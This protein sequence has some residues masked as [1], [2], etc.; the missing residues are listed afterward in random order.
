M[1][2]PSQQ[3]PLRAGGLSSLVLQAHGQV[4]AH[5]ALT[6]SQIACLPVCRARV[7]LPTTPKFVTY[8]ADMESWCRGICSARS[9]SLIS[10]TLAT[11]IPEMQTSAM[12]RAVQTNTDASMQKLCMLA[13]ASCATRPSSMSLQPSAPRLRAGTHMPHGGFLAG[14]SQ[15]VKFNSHCTGMPSGAKDR[16][17]QACTRAVLCRH[18]LCKQP[19]K[20][21]SRLGGCREAAS[22]AHARAAELHRAREKQQHCMGKGWQRGSQA[23]SSKCL[24]SKG[25]FF[26]VQMGSSCARYHGRG[27]AAP[28]P[29]QILVAS[30]SPLLEMDTQQWCEPD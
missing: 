7:Y 29:F 12:H 28:N 3:H 24:P 26:P 16:R 30:E 23:A 6:G 10:K 20:A 4:W 14:I 17:A 19:G 9:A 13:S 25:V 1:L 2:A 5:A 8:G 15:G 27:W 21:A 11:N 22:T 18:S